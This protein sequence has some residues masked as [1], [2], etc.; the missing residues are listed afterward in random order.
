QTL[1]QAERK[2]EILTGLDATGQPVTV[3]FDATATIELP[4]KGAGKRA[5]KKK[6][7]TPEPPPD[8]DDSDDGSTLF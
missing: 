1:E 7:A 5:S 8:V 2:I 3:A 4:K 6:E